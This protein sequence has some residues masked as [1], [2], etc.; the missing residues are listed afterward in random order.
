[1]Q[2]R[3]NEGWI[4]A[5]LAVLVTGVLG[6]GVVTVA[7]DGTTTRKVTADGITGPA[8][9]GAAPARPLDLVGAAPAAAADDKPKAEPVVG[10]KVMVGSDGG[11]VTV[12]GVEDNVSAGRLF[13]AGP[14]HKYIAAEV[15]GCSG[16]H[17][18][19]LSF[20]PNYFLLMLDDGTMHDRGA[21]A[22]KPGPIVLR[23]KLPSRSG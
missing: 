3:A 13:G 20:E 1:M 8:G 12:S 18:K 17:E 14:G 6:G 11:S 9:A 19:N 2:I 23:G 15:K 4:R 10:D 5:G 22:K 16:P 21:G 7:R